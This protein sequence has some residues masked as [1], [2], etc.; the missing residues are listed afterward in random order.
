MREL[1]FLLT[2]FGLVGVFNTL[3]G[4][5]IVATLDVGFGVHP[6]VANAIGY[7]VG[8]VVSYL[9]NSRFVFRS[10]EQAAATAPRFLM[11]A[12]AAFVLNQIVLHF[13]G[14]LLGEHPWSR[15]AAQAMAAGSYTLTFFALCRLWVFKTPATTVRG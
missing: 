6:H 12:A 13:A 14:G 11:A 15:L 2:R 7:G 3:V 9:L 1:F 10:T 8:I 5:G 4:F